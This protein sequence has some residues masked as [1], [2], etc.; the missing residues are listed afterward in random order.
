M[1][2]IAE[3]VDGGALLKTAVA[4]LVAG[5][6][7]TLFFSLA[8]VGLTRSGELRNSGRSAMA[9]LSMTLGVLAL[10]AS[11]ASVGLGL[12]VMIAD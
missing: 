2:P 10:V 12:F 6:G 3:I 8:I 11:I 5:T 9:T 1:I 7:V 4:A